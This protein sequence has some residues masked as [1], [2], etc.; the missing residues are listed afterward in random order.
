LYVTPFRSAAN[1]AHVPDFAACTGSPLVKSA[2]SANPP[3]SPAVANH[4]FNIF[5]VFLLR[6][7]MA[8]LF[9]GSMLREKCS[10]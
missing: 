8:A 6:G 10:G 2:V 3:E 5:I 7:F 9:D 1:E 4:R